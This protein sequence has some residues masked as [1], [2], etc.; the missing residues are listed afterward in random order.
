MATITTATYLDGGTARTA[1]EAWTINSGGSLTVRTDHR[2]HANAPASNTGSLGSVTVSEGGLIWDST[3]VRWM[4]YNSGTGNVPAIG[5]TVSQGGV[6]GYLLGVW[7]SKTTVA[8]TVGSAMPTSGFIKFREVT[9]GTF[10][11]GA[12]TGIGASATGPDVQGWISLP[13]DAAANLTFPRLGYHRARGGRFF[14]E[15]T[16]GARGQVFQVPS[17]GSAV[18]LAPGIMVETAPAS[19]VYEFW[20][21]LNGS[22][23]GWTHIHVGNATGTTDARQKYVKAVAGGTMVMGGF[24]M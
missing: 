12:L 13:F 24:C 15:T 11:S 19:D 16:T 22:T 14:L 18:M 4:P 10:T 20:P 5:T 1:G 6:S 7:A 17:E 9:G 8:T 3:A 21:A 23:N 2:V